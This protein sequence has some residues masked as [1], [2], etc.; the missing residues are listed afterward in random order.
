MIILGVDPGTVVAGYGIIESQP[1][2]SGRET[3]V[4]LAAGEINGGR[5]QPLPVRLRVIFQALTALIDQHRPDCVAVEEPFVDKNIQT[6]LKLGQAEGLVLLA[7]ELAGL[8]SAVYTPATIKLAL[9]GYGRAEKFQIGLMAARLLRLKE[10]PK[11]HHAADALAVAICHLH[12][13]PPSSVR[14]PSAVAVPMPEAIQRPME[15]QRRLG[16]RG[17]RRAH[18]ATK[19]EQR[20]VRAAE[21]VRRLDSEI[22]STGPRIQ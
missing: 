18:A 5:N 20:V 2:R 3:S 13:A 9:T 15:K 1:D 12:S 7:A 19:K 14:R 16:G 22:T 4:C 11:S 17:H 6:A 8:P 21:S 10:P